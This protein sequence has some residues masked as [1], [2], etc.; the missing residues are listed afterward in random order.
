MPKSAH[1]RDYRL[2][3]LHLRS[4]REKAGLTQKD[5]AKALGVHQSYVSKYETG[6]RRLDVIEL[7]HICRVLRIPMSTFLRQLEG[8]LS[9]RA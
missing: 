3:R 2:F 9:R 4:I 7:R 1:S 5:I 6:E 8:V